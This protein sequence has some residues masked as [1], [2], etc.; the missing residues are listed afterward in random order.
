MLQYNVTTKKDLQYNERKRTNNEKRT[1]G[2]ILTYNIYTQKT[3]RT[4]TGVKSGTP[5]VSAVPDQHVTP[6]LLFLL[7]TR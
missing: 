1:K 3:K 6:V 2:Q 5:K 7:Q 4:P